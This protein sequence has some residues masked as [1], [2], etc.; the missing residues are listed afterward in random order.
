MVSFGMRTRRVRT[1][2]NSTWDQGPGGTTTQARL[3]LLNAWSDANETS[4]GRSS[5]LGEVL[6]ARSSVFSRSSSRFST[7]S[8]PFLGR[9][10]GKLGF[11]DAVRPFLALHDLKPVL[12][13][14]KPIEN[15]F[16]A[17]CRGSSAIVVVVR[18]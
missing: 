12:A 5:H 14:C 10:G 17:P 13:R 9:N 6:A 1:F 3:T 7:V 11:W 8:E 2:Y 15:G 16:K 18:R 4:H